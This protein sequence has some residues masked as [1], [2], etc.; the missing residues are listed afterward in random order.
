MMARPPWKSQPVMAAQ[1]VCLG[2]IVMRLAV[3]APWSD[4]DAQPENPVPKAAVPVRPVSVVPFHPSEAYTTTAPKQARPNLPNAALALPKATP[5]STHADS[6]LSD[7]PVAAVMVAHKSASTPASATSP[8]MQPARIPLETLPS[9]ALQP[10]ELHFSSWALI[11]QGHSRA[12]APG[13]LGGAQVGARLVVPLKRDSLS[14]SAGV[15]APLH[16]R[17]GQEAK[18]GFS[19]T[20]IREQSLEIIAERRFGLTSRTPSRFV[21]M[22]VGGF[23]SMR[24]SKGWQA[25]GYAQAGVAGM[26]KRMTFA[27]G[28]ITVTR[29]TD[30]AARSA[31]KAGFGLW[32]SAQPN[33]ARLDIGPVLETRLE[34]KHPVTLSL[35]WRHRIAGKAAPSS[36]PALVIGT[37]F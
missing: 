37:G 30:K 8:A 19:I 6:E 23:D 2:W 29:P 35:Q 18:L 17:Q 36:G 21:I 27:D 7:R 20:P 16:A 4:A 24:V 32:A 9:L 26:R 25:K 5:P 33:L 22:A 15:S 14:V 34:A 28:Q 12:D 13:L 11:R 1:M 3:A 10:R 31:I